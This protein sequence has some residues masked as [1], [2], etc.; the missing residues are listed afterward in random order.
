[1]PRVTVS[2]RRK[3]DTPLAERYP[4]PPVKLHLILLAVALS[5]AIAATLIWLSF[6]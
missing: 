4:R 2:A 6:R 5:V 1:V 3:L